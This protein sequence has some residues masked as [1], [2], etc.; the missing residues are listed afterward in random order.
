MDEQSASLS[1]TIRWL[2]S[3]LPGVWSIS[4]KHAPQWATPQRHRT[5]PSKWWSSLQVALVSDTLGVRLRESLLARSCMVYRMLLHAC[6]GR[7]EHGPVSSQW[8]QLQRYLGK[9]KYRPLACWP[10]GGAK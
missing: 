9:Y 3:L 4:Q 1:I 10:K 5:S 8:G 7:E 6:E 2:T